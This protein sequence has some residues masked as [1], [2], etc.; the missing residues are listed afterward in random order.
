MEASDREA[1]V[2][3]IAPLLSDATS[4]ARAVLSLPDRLRQA[5]RAAFVIEDG[6]GVT[7]EELARVL[8]ALRDEG[9]RVKAV[10]AAGLLAD[11]AGHGLVLPWNGSPGPATY[12]LPWEIQARVP[13]LPGWCRRSA[14]RPANPAGSTEEPAFLEILGQL[15]Q[16]IASEPPL[17]KRTVQAEPDPEPARRAQGWPSHPGETQA[18]QE[19]PKNSDRRPQRL[20]IPAPHMLLDDAHMER[21]TELTHV[22][23]EKLEFALHLLIDLNL[24][25]AEAERLVADPD[26]MERFSRYPLIR[27]K[28]AAAQAYV[29]MLSWSEL[30]TLMRT[31]PEWE[32]T[33]SPYLPV[34]RSQFRSE[35]ARARQ[36]VLR[37]L[38]TAGEGRTCPLSRFETALVHIWPDFFRLRRTRDAH[39][40]PAS[41][42]LSIGQSAGGTPSNGYPPQAAFLRTMLTGPLNWLG[43]AKAISADRDTV[44]I[45]TFGLAE[46]LWR[47]PSEAGRSSPVGRPVEYAPGTGMVKVLLHAVDPQVPTFLAQLCALESA[48]GE[49]LVFRL[50]M[51]TV[52]AA[53]GRGK[54]LEEI[55]MQ[56]RETMPLPMP[57]SFGS[58]LREWWGRYGTVRLYDGFA[59]LEVDDDVTLRELEA[60]TSLAQHIVAKM[61][62][63][64]VLVPEAQV[65]DLV[66]QL[67]ARGHMPRQVA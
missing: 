63:R 11:L 24:A 3:A 34:S 5:L 2:S 20:P 36:M 54:L 41:L 38:A 21:L 22:E 37:F 45:Q 35:L 4:V 27:Q 60:T 33:R 31:E 44:A 16:R 55:Q 67:Q 26:A 14:Q 49:Q 46:L 29:S 8:T 10:E 53:F 18:G 1:Y 47:P 12:L 52:H 58:T 48:D 56:W 61:S 42:H 65:D 59:L 30:D 50:D 9:S 28:R 23:P 62:P 64:M 32:L 43:Y 57:E 19:Q 15:W 66:R 7:P 17:L 13:P 25:R 6:H 51:R 40:V 39:L